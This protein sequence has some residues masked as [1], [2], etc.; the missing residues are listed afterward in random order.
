MHTEKIYINTVISF[1][2]KIILLILGFISRKI[3]LNYL[4]E[5]LVGLS[6]VYSNLLDLLNISELG[7]GTAVQN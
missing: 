3:F 6:A 1:V 2:S 7:I 4:G 5:E